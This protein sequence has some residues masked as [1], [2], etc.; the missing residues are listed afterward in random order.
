V[1]L[2][3]PEEYMID[4]HEV[5]Y[6]YPNGVQALHNV[7][8]LVNKGNFS[9][10]VGPT[11]SG[12]ST[13]LRLIYREIFPSKGEIFVDNKEITEL[14]RS[15]IPHLRR[16][17]GVIF[18][19][20]KLLPQKTVYENVAYALEVTGSSSRE[21]PSKVERALKL[22]N[23]YEKADS[24]PE[25]LSGGE[26]QRVSIA[27]AIVN[28]PLILLADE[29]TGNLDPDTSWEIF[30]LLNKIN[31]R[32]TTMIVATHNKIIV[33]AMLKRVIGLS[34]GKIIF[35]LEKSSYPTKVPELV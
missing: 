20:F 24:F 11:G 1:E 4:I 34:D 5:S 21:I 28:N 17:M 35:D 31:A 19:D 30:Q 6:T 18:Q 15:N 13:I 29:P 33:D 10:L 8:L 23:L 27:R 12:K 9:F 25:E 14:T 7:S 16:K 32:G 22:V 3:I 26:Q 2:S